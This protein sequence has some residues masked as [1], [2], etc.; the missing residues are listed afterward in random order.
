MSDGK[1]IRLTKGASARNRAAAFCERF[2]IRAPVPETPMAGASPVQ[3][4]V[5]VANA[6]GM[7][8]LGALLTEPEGIVGW[9]SQFRQ[10][11]KGAFRLNVWVPDPP[12]RRG[13]PEVMVKITGDRAVNTVDPGRL[14]LGFDFPAVPGR[15]RAWQPVLTDLRRRLG[16]VESLAET[17]GVMPAPFL[18]RHPNIRI[19]LIPYGWSGG[20]PESDAEDAE[21]STR[22][23]R[24]RLLGPSHSELLRIDL[25]DVPEAEPGDEVVLLGRSRAAEIALDEVASIWGMV[26]SSLPP[27]IGR[28]LRRVHKGAIA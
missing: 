18:T 7:G 8:A 24:V 26:P 5:A 23:R 20:F 13:A 1:H 16:M 3:L 10:G 4:A 9:A 11:S 2:G 17:T 14:V 27:V 22:V 25:T 21:A 6:S 19:G 12:P 28:T 15:N